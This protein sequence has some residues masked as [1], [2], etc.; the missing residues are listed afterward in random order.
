MNQLNPAAVSHS[1]PLIPEDEEQYPA[2]NSVTKRKYKSPHPFKKLRR[3]RNHL[4]WNRR[5]FS[6]LYGSNADKKFSSCFCHSFAARCE[7]RCLTIVTRFTCTHSS[8]TPAFKAI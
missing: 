3:C 4:Q 7:K 5:S 6:L 2:T 1:H 8:V